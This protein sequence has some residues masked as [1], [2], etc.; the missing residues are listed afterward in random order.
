M[1]YQRS[2]RRRDEVSKGPTFLLAPTGQGENPFGMGHCANFHWH[3]Q[4]VLLLD[5]VGGWRSF[6]RN[7]KL[8]MARTSARTLFASGRMWTR[9]L[10]IGKDHQRPLIVA[11]VSDVYVVSR[12]CL[13]RVSMLCIQGK[14]MKP[15]G[16]QEEVVRSTAR[17]IATH[18]DALRTWPMAAWRAA[19]CRCLLWPAMTCSI[20]LHPAPRTEVIDV[21]VIYSSK[22]MIALQW[23]EWGSTKFNRTTC[24]CVPT[25]CYC[26]LCSLEHILNVIMFAFS[27]TKRSGMDLVF[28]G[29][30]QHWTAH[31]A[32]CLQHFAS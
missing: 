14:D 17:R 22:T 7:S 30:A 4:I 19:A 2:Q 6:S 20:L 3:C 5:A 9:D 11:G 16:D 8:T 27:R 29:T 24:E 12:L 15:R 21:D 13:G 23:E 25:V 28:L 26:I 31:T 1:L 32:H 10:E 18:C